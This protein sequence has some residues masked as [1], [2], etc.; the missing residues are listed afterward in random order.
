MSARTSH[1]GDSARNTV[2]GTN[3]LMPGKI[4][5]VQMID[6]LATQKK[7]SNLKLSSR[8]LVTNQAENSIKK[9]NTM[10]SVRPN[11]ALDLR[12]KNTELN[13]LAKDISGK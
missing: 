1:N 11:L 6:G 5:L 2:S 10:M 13:G 12:I 8:F 3:S 7:L 9:E 4:S